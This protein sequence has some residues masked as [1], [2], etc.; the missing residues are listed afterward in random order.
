MSH[1]DRPVLSIFDVMQELGHIAAKLN[2]TMRRVLA[3]QVRYVALDP[4][5]AGHA[6]VTLD[7]LLKPDAPK[8]QAVVLAFTKA[9]SHATQGVEPAALPRPVKAVSAPRKRSSKGVC[10][11]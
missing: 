9:K 8:P 11:G 1:Y 4:S 6:A 2:P 3:S 7:V 10:N 5:T